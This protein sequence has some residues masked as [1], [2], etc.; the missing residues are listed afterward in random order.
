MRFLIQRGAQLNTRNKEDNVIDVISKKVPRAMEE[1]SKLLDTGITMEKDKA[2]INLD[3]TKIFQRH[4][5]NEEDT[6]PTSL[7]LDLSQ[8]PFRDLIE[9]PLC[10]TFLQNKLN[11]VVWYFVFFI[12]LP[13]FLFSLV[14]S[15]YSG[16]I[17]GHL[18]AM[19]STDNNRRWEWDQDIPCRDMSDTEV[20]LE[21]RSLILK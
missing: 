8:T 21:D 15:F 12:M 2:T 17:F 6:L 3:F 14:Y 16:F 4:K 19:N 9:H 10:Q 1:F 13:H 11:K 7:F 5:M 18:C 20:S